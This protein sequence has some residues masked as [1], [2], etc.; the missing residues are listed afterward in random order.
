MFPIER[1]LATPMALPLLK[2]SLKVIVSKKRRRTS[3]IGFKNVS[4]RQNLCHCQNRWI[5]SWYSTAA[6]N[7]TYIIR[8][9]YKIHEP[10]L[11]VLILNVYCMYLV[12]KWFL[13]SSNAWKIFRLESA[14]RQMFGV[15]FR[16]GRTKFYY[17]TRR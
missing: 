17:W 16:E 7:L 3:V 6:Y 10:C 12:E 4:R 1:I 8:N 5:L 13:L 2:I 11:V 15:R 14:V 9:S